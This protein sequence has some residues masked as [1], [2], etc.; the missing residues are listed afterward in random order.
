VSWSVLANDEI[1]LFIQSATSL[2]VSAQKWD[3]ENLSRALLI[4]QLKTFDGVTLNIDP[5][6]SGVGCTAVSILNKY[7][8]FP[9]EVTY[10][11]RI[12]PFIL[13]ESDPVTL[14]HD[15]W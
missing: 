8:V 5:L 14:S 9:T 1:G 13:K 3:T 11:I 7:R 12:L 10:T 15:Q 6:V 4:P 2:N